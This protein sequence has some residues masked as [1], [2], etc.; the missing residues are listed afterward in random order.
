MSNQTIQPRA[1]LFDV[2]GT[3]LTKEFNGIQGLPSDRV[4]NAVRQA[5]QKIPTGLITARQPQ[6]SLDLIAHLQLSGLSILSNGA[7][8]WDNKAQKMIIERPLNLESTMQISHDLFANNIS[9][10]IQDNGIDYVL[11]DTPQNIANTPTKIHC[12]WSDYQ[13]TKPFLIVAHKVSLQVARGLEAMFKHHSDITAFLGHAFDDGTYDVF[14]TDKRTTKSYALQE[15]SQILNIPTH[16]IL[17]IGDGENDVVLMENCLG[18]AMGN[19]VEMVKQKAIFIA[20]TVDED[21]VA[22]ALERFVLK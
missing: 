10:W 16:E 7:Q 11:T 1:A 2:D 8:I 15:V 17:G 4:T 5:S 18:I 13:P 22:V 21:G 19:A 14:I 6:K 9:F 12:K 20:P 3:L